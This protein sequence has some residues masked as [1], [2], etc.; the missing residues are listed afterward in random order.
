MCVQTTTGNLEIRGK[1]VGRKIQHPAFE[2]SSFTKSSYYTRYTIMT[3]L[4]S[5]CTALKCLRITANLYHITPN[6]LY[7]LNFKTSLHRRP[8]VG[9]S[10][11]VFCFCSLYFNKLMSYSYICLYPI[12]YVLEKKNKKKKSDIYLFL[13]DLFSPGQDRDGS[14]PFALGESQLCTDPPRSGGAACKPHKPDR[15]PLP[16]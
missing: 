6:L 1:H 8:G 14:S 13:F 4:G 11:K 5:I 12:C 2:M 15:L 16:S 9:G 3:Y 7:S 10:A